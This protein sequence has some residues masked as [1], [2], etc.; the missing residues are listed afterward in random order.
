[1]VARCRCARWRMDCTIWKVVLLSRPVLI[2]S[3]IMTKRGPTIISPDTRSGSQ[4]SC[5]IFHIGHLINIFNSYEYVKI[6]VSLLHTVLNQM[7]RGTTCTCAE[8]WGCSSH[9]CNRD[10][11]DSA[12]V[13]SKHQAYQAVPCH[14]LKCS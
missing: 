11:A 7:F 1:M 2:S 5:I 4:L 6:V 13:T 3:I 12:C 8:H 9:P 10:A 14:H